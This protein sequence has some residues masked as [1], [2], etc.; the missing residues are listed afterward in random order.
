MS[1][2]VTG[3]K[4]YRVYHVML[5]GGERSVNKT[6]AKCVHG[7][8]NSRLHEHHKTYF[9][10]VYSPINFKCIQQQNNTTLCVYVCVPANVTL[11]VYLIRK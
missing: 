5:R 6:I 11:T 10:K 4:H 8:L 2:H 3:W 1:C 9:S 7:F